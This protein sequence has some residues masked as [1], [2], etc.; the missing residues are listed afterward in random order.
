MGSDLF[1]VAGVVLCLLGLWF[2][3]A[4]CIGL[5]WLLFRAQR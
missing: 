5:A 2:A 1:L 4:V 3:G